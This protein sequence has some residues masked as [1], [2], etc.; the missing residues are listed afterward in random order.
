[1]LDPDKVAFRLPHC[2]AVI[3]RHL[4]H[5][6]LEYAIK[7]QLTGH[8]RKLRRT[9]LFKQYFGGA[10]KPMTF[11]PMQI[12]TTV[13]RR[14]EKQMLVHAPPIVVEIDG[15]FARHPITPERDASGPIE[16][17]SCRFIRP[18]LNRS[19]L[20]KYDAGNDP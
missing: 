12:G 19:L 20:R 17:D 10:K 1:L 4:A 9:R 2:R 14:P 16:N 6:I 11:S 7:V 13:S 5:R 15:V 3:A 8:A 18:A